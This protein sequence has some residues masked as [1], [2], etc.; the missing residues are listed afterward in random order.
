[1]TTILIHWWAMKGFLR[2]L[3]TSLAST[4]QRELLTVR[5][6]VVI[7]GMLKL[8]WSPEAMALDT[9]SDSDE[10]YGSERY[11]QLLEVIRE[12]QAR[13]SVEDKRAALTRKED[14]REV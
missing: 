2:A 5:R 4:Y 3:P 8:G 10:G 11:N 1:M 6:E 9:A 13:Y 14:A 7:V 12:V